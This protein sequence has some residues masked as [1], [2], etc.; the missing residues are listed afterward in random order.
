MAFVVLQLAVIKQLCIT[1]GAN[2][3]L[4]GELPVFVVRP[5]APNRDIH[6]VMVQFEYMYRSTPCVV[7]VSLTFLMSVTVT[8]QVESCMS[9]LGSPLAFFREFAVHS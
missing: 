6:T 8:L 3:W 9:H 4:E 1:V 2:F 7:C 5:H